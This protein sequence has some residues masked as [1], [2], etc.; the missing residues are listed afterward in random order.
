M[1][2]DLSQAASSIYVFV[3]F[4]FVAFDLAFSSATATTATTTILTTTA[5]RQQEQQKPNTTT[6]SCDGGNEDVD[7][8]NETKQAEY[9][10]FWR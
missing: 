4:V 5:R 7:N 1:W 9:W 3:F 8:D 6:E 10:S 2:Y